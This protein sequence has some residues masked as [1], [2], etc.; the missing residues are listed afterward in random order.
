MAHGK[1]YSVSSGNAAIY[2]PC[3]QDYTSILEELAYD[4]KHNYSKW[5]QEFSSSDVGSKFIFDIAN[6]N[7][8]AGQTVKINRLV[9]KSLNIPFDVYVQPDDS[10]FI[11]EIPRFT[12]F[13]FGDTMEEAIENIKYELEA[14]Y[15][16]LN[17]DDDFTEEWLEIREFLN[18]RVLD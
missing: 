18:S 9:T 13:G 15:E 4:L 1:Y 7:T 10:G 11:A 8:S 16:E 5:M 17:Q 6:S 2:W 14:L 12:L 3:F